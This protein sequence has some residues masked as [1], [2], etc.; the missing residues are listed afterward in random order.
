MRSI[1]SFTLFLAGFAIAGVLFTSLDRAISDEDDARERAAVEASERAYGQLVGRVKRA[2][3]SDGPRPEFQLVFVATEAGSYVES[4]GHLDPED[5]AILGRKLHALGDM[6]GAPAEIEALVE[7]LE[8]LEE[9]L[10]DEHDEEHEDEDDDH[11]DDHD[12]ED[13]DE[14][15][16]DE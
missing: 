7:E 15:F 14:A 10:E 3:L 11:D 6:V 13:D 1:R 16:D 12:D 2:T 8:E 4:F 5:A 9:E